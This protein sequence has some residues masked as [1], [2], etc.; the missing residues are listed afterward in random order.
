MFIDQTEEL[1]KVML[2]PG[3]EGIDVVFLRRSRGFASE[4]SDDGPVMANG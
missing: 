2:Q 1:R 3:G 4:L